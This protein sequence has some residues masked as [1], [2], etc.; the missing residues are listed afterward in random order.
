MI[1]IEGG[2]PPA[3]LMRDDNGLGSEF[4]S[5]ANTEQLAPGKDRGVRHRQLLLLDAFLHHKLQAAELLRHEL[6]SVGVIPGFFELLAGLLNPGVDHRSQ[7]YPQ[8]V[9]PPEQ[10]FWLLQPRVSYS[11]TWMVWRRCSSLVALGYVCLFV[12]LGRI[13][14]A[15]GYEPTLLKMQQLM[16]FRLIKAA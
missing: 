6:L 5:V 11:I 12:F 8:S 7:S 3:M 10:I 4:A 2:C 13:F 1:L 16:H 15:A 9:Q 14:K